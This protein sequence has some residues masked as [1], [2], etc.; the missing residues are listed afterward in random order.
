M[1]KTFAATIAAATLFSFGQAIPQ[2]ATNAKVEAAAVQT[3]K[4]KVTT[5]LNVRSKASTGGK[6]LGT[7][8][9]GT[10]I[11]IKKKLANGW[12]QISYKGKTA[13]VSGKYVKRMA[14]STATAVSTSSQLNAYEQKVVSLTNAERAKA[15][16][17]PLQVDT[18]LS[19]VARAKSQ[20]MA[21]HNYFSHT[22]PTYG[23]PFDMMKQFGVTYSYAGENIA[24][25]QRTPEEVMTAWMNS[26]GHRANILNKSYTH[27]GVG[28]VSGKNVWTQEF[29]GR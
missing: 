22:S 29:I 15:G 21:S 11:T 12:L 20:D 9:K 4:G 14:S 8:K 19:Q 28:Y 25:G 6:V 27:I 17:R 3:Q 7:L 24:M 16:L 10:I 18:K 2:L 26:A 5:V 1:K 13:Y 23:S